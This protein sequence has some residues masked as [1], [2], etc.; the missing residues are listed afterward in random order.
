MGIDGGGTRS[1][2]VAVDTEGN[3]IA[4][5][6]GGSINYYSNGMQL[7]RHHLKVMLDKLADTHGIDQYESV[8][9][10]NSALNMRASDELIET[11]T[12]GLVNSKSVYMHSDSYIALMSLTVEKPGVLIISGTGSMGMAKGNNDHIVTNGGWGYLLGDEGSAYYI[13][14]Q[15]IKSAIKAHD[16][17]GETTLLQQS[18]HTFFGTESL[19][20]LVE[21]CYNPPMERHVIAGFA[22]EVA[23]CAEQGDNA[24]QGIIDQAIEDLVK[25]AI[26]LVQRIEI[27]E[28]TIGASGGVFTNNP[29]IFNEFKQRL[30]QKYPLSFVTLLEFQPELGAIFA[31]FQHNGMQMDPSI[32]ERMKMSYELTAGGVR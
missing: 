16:N 32:K 5:V 2:A 31:C 18:L 12:G 30:E 7:A 4:K 11:F 17:R 9:I 26:A 3:V 6:V 1:T 20:D 27:F 29:Y 19:D 14:L 23:R 15:G 25:H 13:A 28:I 22:S 8:F 10:G 24:A 21:K